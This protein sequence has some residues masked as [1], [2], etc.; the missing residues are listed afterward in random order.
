VTDR[1]PRA[2]AFYT[3]LGFRPAGERSEL[4]PGEWEER[5]TRPLGYPDSTG[6]S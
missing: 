3:R 1:N 2:R 6:R 4:R 5:M